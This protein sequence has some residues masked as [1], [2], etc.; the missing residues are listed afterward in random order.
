MSR[1][2]VPY[3]TAVSEIEKIKSLPHVDIVGAFSHFS[4]SDAVDKSFALLQNERMKNIKFE[5][6][7]RGVIIPVWHMSNSG[8]TLDLP[9]AHFDMVRV[10]LMNYGY[11]PSFD[12]SNPFVLKPAMSLKSKI[13]AIRDV[14]RGDTVGYGR[15]YMVEKDERIAVLPIGYADGYNRSLSKIGH[16]LYKGARLPIVGG[17]CMD[18]AFINISGIPDIGIGDVVTLMGIDGG[19]EISPHEIGGLVG[20]VSYDVISNFGRRLPRVYVR[21]GAVQ[22]INNV[23]TD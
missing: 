11:W 8:G 23:L 6:E 17:L 12:V 21:G 22:Q 20:S 15:K 1:F 14:K 16:V 2:G 4:V 3:E 13:V 18:A 19:E 7:K 5:L 10:G 9:Q